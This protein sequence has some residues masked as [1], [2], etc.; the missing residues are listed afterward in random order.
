MH[1]TGGT[2]SGSDQLGQDAAAAV[3]KLLEQYPASTAAAWEHVARMAYLDGYAAGHSDATRHAVH[4]IQD[5][6]VAS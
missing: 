2:M 3:E 5:T 6:E 4:V 1:E